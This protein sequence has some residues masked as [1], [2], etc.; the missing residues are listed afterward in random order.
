MKSR[1]VWRL[2]FAASVLGV[3]ASAAPA[4]ARVPASVRRLA[5]GRVRVVVIDHDSGKPL[6]S[7][8]IATRGATAA[9]AQQGRI[10][11]VDTSGE[12]ELRLPGGEH[13][14]TVTRGPEYTVDR[15]VVNVVADGEQQVTLSLRRVVDTPGWAACDF[16]VHAQGSFDSHVPAAERVRSLLAAGLDFAVPTEHDRVGSYAEAAA[17]TTLAWVP[18]VE[19]TTKRG[20]FNVFPFSG[21][22]APRSSGVGLP[23]VL[24]EVRRVS[25]GSL[26]QVNHPRLGDGM[27]YFHTIQLDLAKG[28]G[29][30]SLPVG[31]DTLEVYNGMELTRERRV[32]ATLR[33][34]LALFEAGRTHWATGGSDVH[35]G[36]GSPPGYPRT[37]VALAADDDGA[38][39]KPVDAAALVASLKQ[40]HATVTSGPFVELRQDGRG[41]GDELR[42]VD[43]KARVE[44]VVRAAPWIDVAEVQLLSGGEVVHSHEPRGRPIEVGPPTGTLED[45]RAA[46]V[47]FRAT[48][49]VPIPAGARGLVAVARS[50]Q[51][52]GAVLPGVDFRP[53]GFSNPML[54]VR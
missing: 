16:H 30:A 12:T 46:A 10:V 40:G 54:V 25:P 7:R 32:D 18:G 14:I 37:Y 15:R 51:R 52:V 43:G 47:R 48:V 13:T 31:F 5:F 42:V 3:A 26:V 49:D 19:T 4:S 36:H 17:G 28:R 2:S 38:A 6:V 8:V 33:E 24:A 44:I 50:G 23:E 22:A 29:L 35:H 9:S 53:M 39:G 41:P 21:P 34:W 27:G 20:H 11:T 45:A 1:V